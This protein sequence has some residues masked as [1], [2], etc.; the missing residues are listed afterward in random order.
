MLTTHDRYAP[1]VPVEGAE[2]AAAEAV[3]NHPA[4]LPGARGPRRVAVALV[5]AITAMPLLIPSGPGNTA[6][7][8]VGILAVVVTVAAW[9]R[10]KAVPVSVPYLL[11]VGILM[12]AGSVAAYHSG[13]ALALLPVVQD[14]FLLVWAACIANAVRQYR[15][16][17]AA[18]LK[19]WVWS[20][21]AW[22]VVLCVGKMA[23]ISWMAGL[24]SKDGGRA[25]LTFADPNL[26]A[27]YF[28]IVVAL[29][30]A[31]SVVR[32][33]WARFL[34]LCTVLLA[35]VFTGSNG[36]AIGLGAMVATSLVVG[37]VRRRGVVIATAVA[38]VTVA[39]FAAVAPHIDLNAIGSKA[40]DSVQVLRDSLGRTDESS[41]SR[42]ELATETIGLYLE[43]DLLGVGPGRTKATLSGQAAPYIKEAHN[44][45][46]ATIVERGA[47]G[48]AGL[49]VLII[50]IA[51]RLGRVTLWPQDPEVQALVPR[52]QWLLGLCC[53]LA[54][55]GLFY[56]VLH[57]RHVWALFGLIAGLDPGSRGLRPIA[58]VPEGRAS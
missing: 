16:L 58:R 14:L 11:P 52:P 41:G 42:T 9:L 44:D 34:A 32:R 35:I 17:L 1:D 24:S 23:N 15:W 55:A 18:V 2:T 39:T 54:V 4:T 51:F 37:M 38:C 33:R 46:L 21:L 8:D 26:C 57:F 43:G 31:T 25:S 19:A 48:G 5:V 27:N 3:P 6:I 13:D 30:L 36:A 7:A 28:L 40:S 53:A 49:V 50:I 45:Y 10:I 29:L 20:G 12:L 22:A 47:A 56:E